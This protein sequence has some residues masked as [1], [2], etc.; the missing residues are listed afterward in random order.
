MNTSLVGGSPGNPQ[1]SFNSDGSGQMVTGRK[2]TRGYE[3]DQ[4]DPNF[5]FSQQYQCTMKQVFPHGGG[6]AL[7]P[8]IREMLG[9]RDIFVDKIEC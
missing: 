2:R 6:F 8:D 5:D 4:V 9:N 1:G 7:N 3:S